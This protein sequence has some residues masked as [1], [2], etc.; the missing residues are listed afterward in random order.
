[1]RSRGSA[2]SSTTQRYASMMPWSGTP[3]RKNGGSRQPK[4]PTSTAWRVSSTASGSAA[5]LV[6]TRMRF[7]GTPPAIRPSIAARRSATE[8]EGPSPVVPNG[9]TPA[10]PASSNRRA[11]RAKVGMSIASDSVSGVSSAGQM[12]R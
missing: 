2:T 11:W 10:Q 3:F 12:P 1:M 8:N 5:Q 4:A 9:V 7:A 6:D